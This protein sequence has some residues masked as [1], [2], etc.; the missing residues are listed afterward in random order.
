MALSAVFR[1]LEFYARSFVYVLGLGSVALT[2]VFTSL[3]MTIIGKR[4]SAPWL[5]AR[6]FYYGVGPLGKHLG[7]AETAVTDLQGLL[8]AV[9]VKFKIEGQEHLDQATARPTIVSW[10]S[11]DK[12]P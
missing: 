10:L 8:L 11:H 9:G 1:R 6:I 12:L 2:G 4:A 7:R 3:F 5:V